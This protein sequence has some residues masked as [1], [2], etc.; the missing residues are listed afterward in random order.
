MACATFLCVPELLKIYVVFL[1]IVI[2]Y[3]WDLSVEL[4]NRYSARR[5]SNAGQLLWQPVVEGTV[6]ETEKS[7][8][9]TFEGVDICVLLV[10]GYIAYIK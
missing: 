9:N 1:G 2:L 7:K 4:C 3:R 10:P 6:C 8:E 5:N